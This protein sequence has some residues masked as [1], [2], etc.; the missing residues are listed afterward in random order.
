MR[1]GGLPKTLEPSSLL[2]YMVQSYR[3]AKTLAAT[4]VMPND[5]ASTVRRCN[6]SQWHRS[7]TYEC[8]LGTGSCP[9]NS[10]TALPGNMLPQL[11]LVEL[12][13]M[14]DGG[15]VR[16]SVSIRASRVAVAAR[17]KWGMYRIWGR[18]AERDFRR[19]L[20]L[21]VDQ[22]HHKFRLECV[23]AWL[24]WFSLD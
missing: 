2:S 4:R 19:S 16:T 21:G 10:L 13:F 9:I 8:L 20:L 18:G 17:H 5:L 12:S 11:D 6:R 24:V 23:F 14:F 7:W 15:C 3:Q 22:F 1:R